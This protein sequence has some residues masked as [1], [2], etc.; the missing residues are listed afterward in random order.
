MPEKSHRTVKVFA[1]LA[2]IGA[3]IMARGMIPE[4]YRYIRIRRM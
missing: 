2:M 3:A 4:L 1:V